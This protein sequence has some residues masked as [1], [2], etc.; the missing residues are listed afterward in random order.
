MLRPEFQSWWRRW[1]AP[2]PAGAVARR[3]T[4][5][6]CPECRARYEPRDRYCPGCHMATPEWRYG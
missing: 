5:R 4:P 1:L 6:I 2:Q 3:Q